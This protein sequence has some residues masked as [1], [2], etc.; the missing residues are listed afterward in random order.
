MHSLGCAVNDRVTPASGSSS[1]EASGRG[2]AEGTRPRHRLATA[3]AGGHME[4]HRS[5][6]APR[7]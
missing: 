1:V 4:H 3:A 5:P 2:G 7:R 6:V